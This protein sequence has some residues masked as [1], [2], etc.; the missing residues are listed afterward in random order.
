MSFLLDIIS[1]WAAQTNNFVQWIKKQL[2]NN[3]FFRIY[4]ELPRYSEKNNQIKFLREIPNKVF[5]IHLSFAKL[6]MSKVKAL[7][8]SNKLNCVLWRNY[9]YLGFDCSLSKLKICM[10]DLWECIFNKPYSF[11]HLP[12]SSSSFSRWDLMM[13]GF[14]WW[15]ICS[16]VEIWVG[17][18]WWCVSLLTSSSGSPWG[19]CTWGIKWI[20]IDSRARASHDDDYLI[21]SENCANYESQP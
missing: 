9:C 18:L 19:D 6:K 3:K 16:G 2:Y 11:W 12:F 1:L 21:F 5:N 17:Y 4:N 20:I 7:E 14:S 10:Y 13:S 8:I 15:S